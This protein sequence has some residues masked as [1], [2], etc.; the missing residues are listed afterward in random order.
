METYIDDPDGRHIELIHR[1]VVLFMVPYTAVVILHRQ[2]GIPVTVLIHGINGSIKR[3]KRDG[4]CI[5]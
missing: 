4:T 5:R 1:F 3:R 2:V